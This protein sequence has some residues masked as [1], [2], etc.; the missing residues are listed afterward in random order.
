MRIFIVFFIVAAS[1]LVF[2]KTNADDLPDIS[3]MSIEEIEKLP[4]D[5]IPQLPASDVFA[6]IAEEK[7]LSSS[8]FDTALIINLSK[9]LFFEPSEEQK[10]QAVKAFQKSIGNKADGVLT[11][12]QFEEL[13]RRATRSTDTPVYPSTFGEDIR[14][15]IETDFAIAEGTWIIEGQRIAYPINHSKITCRKYSGVCEVVQADVAVPNLDENSNSYSLH[16]STENYEV[17]S[18]SMDEVVSQ[19]VGE[20]R[21]TLMTMSKSSG[22]VF[23]VTS[24]VGKEGCEIGG[25]L[26]LPQLETPQVAKMVGGFDTAQKFWQERKTE[27]SKFY[28]PNIVE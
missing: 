15:Y 6:K 12:G 24:N 19:S 1:S 14:V 26:A 16:L 22:E 11:M 7:K 28:G 10:I 4:A 21:K 2:T 20:C 27:I 3:K 13:G 8:F 25:L 9:L 17:I 18:W 5:I 23:Q